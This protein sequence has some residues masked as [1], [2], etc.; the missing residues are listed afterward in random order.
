QVDPA[1]PALAATIPKIA[2]LARR[3]DEVVVLARTAAPAELP[4]NVRVRLFDA[5]FQAARGVRFEA[6]LARELSPR[7]AAVVAHVAPVFA[8]LAAPRVRPLGIPLLLWFTHWK[9]SRT[10]AAAE[11]LSTAVL[12]VDR[13][14]F[15]LASAKV[16][17]IG[18]GIDMSEFP[19]SERPPHDG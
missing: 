5:P 2:A 9:R 3:V 10:L 8:V 4:P 1:H 7:P 11:R 18:H 17:A 14:T 12:T 13:R 19:C 6:A 16:R 15:P